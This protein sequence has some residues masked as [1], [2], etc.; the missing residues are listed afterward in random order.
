MALISSGVTCLY[1]ASIH[2]DMVLLLSMFGVLILSGTL[3]PVMF[4]HATIRQKTQFE[5]EA[6]IENELSKIAKE[7]SLFAQ[8]VWVFRKRW[9]LLLHGTVQSAVTAAVNRLQSTEEIDELTV[10]LVKQDLLRAERA[11]NSEPSSEINFDSA[12]KEL[13]DVWTGICDVEVQISERARRALL[14]NSDSAFCVNEIAKEAISN[15]VRHGTAHKAKID[16]DRIEDDLLHIEISN[17]G[18]SPRN[19]GMPGIGSQMLD[20]I[21]LCWELVS[22][23]RTVIL[24]ADLPIRI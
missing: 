23:T 18:I 11:I 14:R 24:F 17:D 9:L 6:Q 3:A 7:N 16:I 5:L 20:E 8:R 22:K 15:A 21:C 2:L 13:R 19:S 4:A 1:L 12:M 10:Q